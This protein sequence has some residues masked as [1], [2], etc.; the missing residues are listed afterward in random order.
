MSLGFTEILLLAV[1]VLILFGRGRVA[2]LMGEFGK[3]MRSFKEGLKGGDKP[4]SPGKDG[5]G[6]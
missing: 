6:A 2:D 5:G 4:D 1:V 3:G